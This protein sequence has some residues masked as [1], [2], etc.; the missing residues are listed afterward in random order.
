[1]KRYVPPKH[2]P[3]RLE[4]TYVLVGVTTFLGVAGTLFALWARNVVSSFTP[5][6]SDD[7][8]PPKNLPLP[9]VSTTPSPLESTVPNTGGTPGFLRAK[10]L[11]DAK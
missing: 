1:M 11:K 2:R 9:V 5:V 3:Q 7:V 4:L 10:R 6:P 8:R